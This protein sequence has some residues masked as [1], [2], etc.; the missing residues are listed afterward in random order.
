MN[1][2][3]SIVFITSFNSFR[4]DGSYSAYCSSKAA[5][6]MFMKCAAIDLGKRGIR[7]NSVAP[8]LVDTPFHDK[9]FESKEQK[10]EVF[11]KTKSMNPNGRIP[12][13]DGIANAVLF[14]SS[15]LAE[16]IT[17]HEQI[18]DCG[19]MLCY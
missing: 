8:G 12:S 6:T 7:V 11:Q 19:G 15:N 14:L 10:E 2:N 16:D 1:K 4:P 17:G 3:G 13:A 18:V 5:L 9:I